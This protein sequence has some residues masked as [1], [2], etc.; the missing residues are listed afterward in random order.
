MILKTA[1]LILVPV[2]AAILIATLY[3]FSKISP[4]PAARAGTDPQATELP[5]TEDT[6]LSGSAAGHASEP[7]ASAPTAEPPVT[8]APQVVASVESR[9]PY[10]HLKRY[11]RTRLKP[12]LREIAKE[13][14]QGRPARISVPLFDDSEAVL[15]MDNFTPYGEDGGAFS[16]KVEGDDGSFVCISFFQ[17]AESGSIQQ[18]AQN[19]VYTIQPEPDGSVVVGEVDVE[20]LGTCGSVPG[21]VR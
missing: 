6:G 19:L 10:P 7:V 20:A 11:F 2:V 9:G 12:S 13:F 18:P 1:V 5:S 21:A 17:D 16:G 4:L 15:V 8:L 3:C 14:Q